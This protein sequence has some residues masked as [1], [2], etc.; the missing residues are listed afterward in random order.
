MVPYVGT[1]KTIVADAG[2]TLDVWS[3]VTVGMGVGD[4]MIRSNCSNVSPQ[5]AG[6]VTQNNSVKSSGTCRISSGMTTAD[7]FRYKYNS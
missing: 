1:P 5:P 3:S 4:T 2:T 7:Y 6:K